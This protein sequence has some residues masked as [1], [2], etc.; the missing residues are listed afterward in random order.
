MKH[1]RAWAYCVVAVMIATA[2]LAASANT[3]SCAASD[4]NLC[5]ISQGVKDVLAVSGRSPV[6]PGVSLSPVKFT[7]TEE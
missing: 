3:A 5:P 2:F 7:E 4:E 1:R 6:W